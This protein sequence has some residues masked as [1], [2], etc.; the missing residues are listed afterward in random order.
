MCP[1]KCICRNKFAG[2]FVGDSSYCIQI[3]LL[4]INI[5]SFGKIVERKILRN[6][7]TAKSIQYYTFYRES[8]DYSSTDNLIER[9]AFVQR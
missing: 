2:L 6:F 5:C 4:L 3:N 8:I 7:V 1:E 9:I